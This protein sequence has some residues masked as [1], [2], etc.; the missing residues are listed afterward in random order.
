MKASD[1][2]ST[3]SRHFCFV[4]FFVMAEQLV[5][6]ESL[7]HKTSCPQDT[8]RGRTKMKGK[9]SRKVHFHKEQEQSDESSDTPQ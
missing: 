4:L 5:C 7:R 6:L 3:I 9:K 2:L 1:L 8:K